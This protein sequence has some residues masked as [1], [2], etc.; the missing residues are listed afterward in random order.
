MRRMMV[1][2]LVLALFPAAAL[3]ETP[4][5]ISEEDG[6]AAALTEMIGGKANLWE[7]EAEAKL[8]A[9][10]AEETTPPPVS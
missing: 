4:V 8:S 2:A 6:T 5:H 7:N 1:L 9:K 10:L 3:T